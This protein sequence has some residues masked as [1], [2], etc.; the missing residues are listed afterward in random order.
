[1]H[2]KICIAGGGWHNQ[3]KLTKNEARNKY[4]SLLGECSLHFACFF[5]TQFLAASSSRSW[6]VSRDFHAYGAR[7]AAGYV[8]TPGNWKIYT[9][10]HQHIAFS[11]VLP[12]CIFNA[13]KLFTVSTLSPRHNVVFKAQLAAANSFLLPAIFRPPCWPLGDA[14]PP[15]KSSTSPPKKKK[16]KRHQL[17]RPTDL[18]D[19]GVVS[20]FIK[21][22]L[23]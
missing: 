5:F 7:R 23:P 21:I 16:K 20:A 19:F 8:A 9:P 14:G 4:F 1:M 17:V 2:F 22:L 13:C 12:C 11:V 15:T 6:L 3:E 10:T 18:T